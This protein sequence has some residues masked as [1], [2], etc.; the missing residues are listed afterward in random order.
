MI[1]K[2]LKDAYADE[3]IAKDVY[4]QN[5]LIL[6]EGTTLTKSLKE[7]LKKLGVNEIYVQSDTPEK[8]KKITTTGQ[9]QS[10]SQSQQIEENSYLFYET[11][12]EIFLESRYGLALNNIEEIHWLSNLFT[13]IITN[14]S[15]KLLTQLKEWDYDSFL[16]S[17][18]VFIISSLIAKMLKVKNIEEFASGCLLH[19]IGKKS[20][21]KSVLQKTD[22]LTI[23]E[24]N[25]LKEHVNHGEKILSKMNFSQKILKL[26]KHHHERLDGNGYPSQLK[27]N[28]IDTELRILSV[29]DVF[30]ALSLK[31]HYRKA[32]SSIEAIQFLLNN[33]EQFDLEIIKHLCLLL[34]IY[35]PQTTVRLSNEKLAKIMYVNHAKPYLPLIQ[36]IQTESTFELP[37][38]FTIKVTHINTF[39]QSLVKHEQEEKHEWKKFFYSLIQGQRNDAIYYFEKL[40][41]GMR[42][43]DIYTN[44]F[45]K[46]LKEIGDK[47]EVGELTIAEEHIVSVLI[48]EIMNIKLP[49]YIQEGITKGKVALLTLGTEQHKLPLKIV[50]DALE[51]NGWNIHNLEVTLPV[52]DLL[53]FLNKKKIDYVGFSVTMPHNLQLLKRVIE[54]I[55]GHSPHIGILLGGLA[56]DSNHGF[57]GCLYANDAKEAVRIMNEHYQQHKN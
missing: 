18:D 51:V 57:K 3:I 17:F 31:R 41:D 2:K 45:A 24:Y 42:V 4:Y 5:K 9:T 46:I 22:K 28:E 32:L 12:K 40:A 52:N 48:R 56:L 20:I 23:E 43:E 55:Q 6:K 21:Q 16:H 54:R 7:K 49:N 14:D 50:S 10:N 36:E 38:D 8:K 33:D 39:D 1:M 11:L 53:A 25:Q 47:W 15:K 29:V 44:I 30:S 27:E 35:P 26:T 19:D 37:T 13:K 34:Q